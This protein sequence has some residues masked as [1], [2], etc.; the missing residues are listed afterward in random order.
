MVENVRAVCP[1]V[2][3]STTKYRANWKERIKKFRK[4]R[5]Q[6]SEIMPD[7]QSFFFKFAQS[8]QK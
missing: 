5:V 1:P 3:I 4:T 2:H 6:K 8:Q 7:D